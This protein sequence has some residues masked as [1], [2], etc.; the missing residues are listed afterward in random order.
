MFFSHLTLTGSITP[1]H[2]IGATPSVYEQVLQSVVP[3]IQEYDSDKQF[4]V[5]GFGTRLPPA[6]IV[7]NEFFVNF[8]SNNPYC[9]GLGGNVTHQ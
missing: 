9:A 8:N 4:P 2:L 5:L 7:S 3:I 1:L 6:G